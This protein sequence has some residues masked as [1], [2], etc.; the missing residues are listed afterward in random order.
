M[1]LFSKVNRKKDSNLFREITFSPL[2]QINFF[3]KTKLSSLS[4]S[5]G[6]S[7]VFVGSLNLILIYASW[8]QTMMYLFVDISLFKLFKQ[9]VIFFLS[10][11][12]TKEL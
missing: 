1:P 4:E 9:D 11:I 12:I 5:S 10:L 7:H 2:T 8:H 3:I 6:R